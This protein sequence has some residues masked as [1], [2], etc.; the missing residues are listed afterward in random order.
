MT[1]KISD[2][3]WRLLRFFRCLS[4]HERSEALK[5]IGHTAMQR[6]TPNRSIYDL[7][8]AAAGIEPEGVQ[9]IFEPHSVCHVIWSG[10]QE[11]GDPD[12]YLLG[13]SDWDEDE[14]IPRFVY[15]A[16][17]AATDQG[18]YFNY[19][20][21]FARKYIDAWRFQIVLACEQAKE[22]DSA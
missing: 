8:P 2:D 1:N 21:D 11:T 18:S 15:G 3:E 17:R 10:M 7:M 19:D 12:A 5:Q 22:T 20:E 14:T 6:C 9:H 16:D 13:T 4:P